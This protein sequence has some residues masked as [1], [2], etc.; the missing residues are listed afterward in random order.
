MFTLY[1]K[2]YMGKNNQ[3]PNCN[4]T[5]TKLTWVAGLSVARVQIQLL[6]AQNKSSYNLKTQVEMSSPAYV[7]IW[8][9]QLKKQHL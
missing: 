8:F 5:A 1:G 3:K 2:H 6:L 4:M 7:C 9:D